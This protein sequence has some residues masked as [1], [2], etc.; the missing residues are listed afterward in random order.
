MI[1]FEKVGAVTDFVEGVLY[2]R[3]VGGK[4]VVVTRAN[5]RFYALSDVCTHSGF[6]ITPG[7]TDGET[8]LCPVHGAVFNIETGEPVEGPAGDPLPVYSVRIEGDE[9]FVGQP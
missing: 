7:T 9:V 6:T 2:S 4:A 1:E 5:G 8:L 3:R